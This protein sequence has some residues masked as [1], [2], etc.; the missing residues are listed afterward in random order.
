VQLAGGEWRCID[1]AA[2]PS[3]GTLSVDSDQALAGAQAML[4]W[5]AQHTERT[6]TDML[7]MNGGVGRVPSLEL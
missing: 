3:W 6:F 5:R 4:T 7:V 2:D 1:L